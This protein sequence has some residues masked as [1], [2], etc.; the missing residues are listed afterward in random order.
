[1]HCTPTTSGENRQPHCFLDHSTL[2]PRHQ[3][4]QNMNIYSHHRFHSVMVSSKHQHDPREPKDDITPFMTASNQQ[5]HH[6]R[7]LIQDK[8]HPKSTLHPRYLCLLECLAIWRKFGLLSVV[9]SPHSTHH[10]SRVGGLVGASNMTPT[11][12]GT[13]LKC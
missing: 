3:A 4:S 2:E 13:L 9:P 7:A 12:C 10:F 1:M 11:S 5:Q 8:S 6:R